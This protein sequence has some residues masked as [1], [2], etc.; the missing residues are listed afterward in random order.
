MNETVDET[1]DA[2]KDRGLR[3]RFRTHIRDEVKRVALAQ[4]AAGGP[5]AL[6]VN[7]IGKEL[8]VSGPALY[9]YFANRDELLTELISDAYRDLTAALQPARDQQT[10]TP[11]RLSALAHAYRDW[12]LSQPARYR[13]LFAAPLAGYDAQAAPLVAASQGAMDVLIDVVRDLHPGPG[14]DGTS[15]AAPTAGGRELDAQLQQWMAARGIEQTEPAVARR[16]VLLWAS[17][18]GLVSLEIGENFAS[19]GLDGDLLFAAAVNGWIGS[20]PS[21]S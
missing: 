6:S 12:A 19:M 3:G 21:R 8:G 13:L 15:G 2:G 20:I 9:R 18:H 5:Q 17:V 7:A 14:P 4:L 10:S 11:D 1:V 16:A